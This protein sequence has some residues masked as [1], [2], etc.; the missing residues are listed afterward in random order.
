MKEARTSQQALPEQEEVDNLRAGYPD[1]LE[2]EASTL[3]AAGSMESS[4]EH[5]IM[6]AMQKL[7]SRRAFWDGLAAVALAL[8]LLTTSGHQLHL[9]EKPPPLKPPELSKVEPLG[10]PKKP[11]EEP[12]GPPVA[13][14]K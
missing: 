5:N 9:V 3:S 4:I 12:T 13:T 8:V 2:E 7:V 10:T 1:G 6:K 14:G 11:K